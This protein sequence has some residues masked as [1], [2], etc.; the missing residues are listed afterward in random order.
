MGSQ[1]KWSYIV[2]IVVGTAITISI[3]TNLACK[4]DA[5]CINS[6]DSAK[7][8]TNETR[9][10]AFF[11]F[12]VDRLKQ[13]EHDKCEDKYG[14]NY[15]TDNVT[16]EIA[17]KEKCIKRIPQVL[18]AGVQKSGTSAL[19]KFLSS[20]PEIVG[21]VNRE[22][23]YFDIQYQNL[24]LTWYR[25]LMPC[26]YSHQ[27]TLE[28]SPDYFYIKGTAK[29]VFDTDPNMKIIF[30]VKDPI[31]RAE[32]AYAMMN[33]N[34]SVNEKTFEELVTKMDIYNRTVID[35]S[36]YIIRCSDYATNV[37]PWLKYFTRKQIVFVDGHNF[38]ENPSEEL[39]VI[40]K[41]L[42]ISPYFTTDSFVFNETT[43]MQCLVLNSSYTYCLSTRTG[44]TH[45]TYSLKV[46]KLLEHFF[47]PLNEDFFRLINR[48]FDW[49]Y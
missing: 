29:R 8:S 49:G 38:M 18:I 34:N 14:G 7:L 30:I 27:I 1:Q 25:D 4:V 20:H 26:S 22:V 10:K 17:K 45:P 2:I 5:P 35:S 33:T 15:I 12:L 6:Q 47:K 41:F 21:C 39:R 36:R 23:H 9:D 43:G 44:L 28:K 11:V 37:M 40:E 19:L 32:S 13:M 42:E 48:R 31:V 3:F 16:L 24:P 46:R